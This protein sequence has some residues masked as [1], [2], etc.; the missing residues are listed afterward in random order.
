MYGRWSWKKN[1]VLKTGHV[2]VEQPTSKERTI[3]QFAAK[4]NQQEKLLVHYVTQKMIGDK[5]I[6]DNV[7]IS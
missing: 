1:F 6:V 7:K 2:N 3:A 4:E 5:N